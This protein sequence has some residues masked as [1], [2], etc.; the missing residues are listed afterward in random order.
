MAFHRQSCVR[1]LLQFILQNYL[2]SVGEIDTRLV[3]LYIWDPISSS[4][5]GSPDPIAGWFLDN[6]LFILNKSIRYAL[7]KKR[8][9]GFDEEPAKGGS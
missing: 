1:H 2:L 8:L 6:Y 4:H 3:R 5:D 7:D 9:P